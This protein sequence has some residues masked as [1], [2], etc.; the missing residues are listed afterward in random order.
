MPVNPATTDWSMWRRSTLRAPR[1]GNEIGP[2][3]FYCGVTPLPAF[4]PIRGC[5]RANCDI[6][7]TRSPALCAVYFLVTD[8][9]T[10][11]RSWE[12]MRRYYFHYRDGPS[13]FED[14]VGEVFADA[15]LARQHATKIAG[16]LVGGGNRSTAT[17]CVDHSTQ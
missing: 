11:D 15:S 13:T 4:H 14:D 12:P 9:R 8:R 17:I 3:G 16:E 1:H 7:P 2:P 6:L 10:F 5:C